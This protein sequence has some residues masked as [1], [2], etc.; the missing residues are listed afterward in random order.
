MIEEDYFTWK[1]GT[2]KRGGREGDSWS[3]LR[4]LFHMKG[5]GNREGGGA[6]RATLIPLKVEI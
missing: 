5:G 6:F 4:R 1:E 3:D 2:R